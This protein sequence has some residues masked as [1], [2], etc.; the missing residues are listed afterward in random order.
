MIMTN[1]NGIYQ[2]DIE[3]Y[4]CEE[5]ESLGVNLGY[6]LI[7]LVEE[8]NGGVLCEILSKARETVSEE[9]GIPIPRVRI[10]DRRELKKLEYS[11]LFK[12]AEVGR[13]TFMEDYTLFFVT[14]SDAGYRDMIVGLED[15]NTYQL[16]KDYLD[17]FRINT[18]WR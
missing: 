16:Y 8:E 4:Y 2:K 3:E 12:G 1:E 10:R 11:L 15:K 14:D 7:P 9:T 17:N 18:G 6:G 13:W 5:V